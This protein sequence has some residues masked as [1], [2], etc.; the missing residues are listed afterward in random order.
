[1][2]IKRVV[3]LIILS[4]VWLVSGKVHAGCIPD[5]GSTTVSLSMDIGRITVPAEAPPGT[6]LTTRSWTLSQPNT[7][8]D[9]LGMIPFGTEASHNLTQPIGSNLYATNIAGIGLRFSLQLASGVTLG[10]PEGFQIHYN[11]PTK[12]QLAGAI[13]KV[14]VVKTALVTGSGEVTPGQYTLFGYEDRIS[15]SSIILT[16]RL[17]PQ[18][19]VIVSSSCRM[20]GGNQQQV[21][22]RSIDMSQLR[23]VGSSAG[24]QPFTLQLQ[25]QGSSGTETAVGV[26]MTWDGEIAENTTLSGG[27]LKNLDN[28]P[29]AAQGIGIQVLDSYQQPLA[30]RQ[31][32]SV[33]TLND[34]A[35]QSIILPFH[36]RYYQY[37]AEV[38]PGLVE[39]LMT[40]NINY[41]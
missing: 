32:Y 38:S 23:G 3:P 19:L 40:F 18:S 15:P 27:V 10:Y 29:I 9:C 12:W 37:A 39:A 17:N 25:C 30:F 21:N 14:E 13:F 26:K 11:S 8:Y 33:A 28:R 6:V 22:L 31:A 5:S 2:S 34:Q 20:V 1:M 16:T 41:E 4:W 36:V 24:Q 7:V 35:S